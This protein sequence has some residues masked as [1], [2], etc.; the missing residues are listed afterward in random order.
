MIS[1]SRM[2]AHPAVNIRIGVFYLRKLYGMFNGASE[3][4]A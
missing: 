4:T 2:S 3:P 1:I